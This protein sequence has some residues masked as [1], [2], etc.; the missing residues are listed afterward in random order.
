M[1]S[2]GGGELRPHPSGGSA[3]DWPICR[4]ERFRRAAPVRLADPWAP[5]PHLCRH[6]TF[7]RRDGAP[8]GPVGQGGAPGEG[9]DLSSE[10][11]YSQDA[12]KVRA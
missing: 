9:W 8:G 6:V 10:L 4:N 7:G 2:W 3:S 5:H 12:D 1:G 11:E